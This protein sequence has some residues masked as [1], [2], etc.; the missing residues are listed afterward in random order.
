[1]TQQYKYEEPDT[2]GSGLVLIVCFVTII[3]ITMFIGWALY[4]QPIEPVVID[5]GKEGEA[6]AA[7]ILQLTGHTVAPEHAKYVNINITGTTLQ[8]ETHSINLFDGKKWREL[9]R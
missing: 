2:K 9:E 7:L 3:A 8:I 5:A 1:M 4:G 6:K